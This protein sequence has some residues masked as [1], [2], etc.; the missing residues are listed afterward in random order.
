MFRNT[1]SLHF[2]PS[3]NLRCR[4]RLVQF[5]VS[6]TISVRRVGDNV[7]ASSRN[8]IMTFMGD[9]RVLLHNASVFNRYL[10]LFNCAVS[11]VPCSIPRFSISLHLLQSFKKG[12]VFDFM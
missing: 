3:V 12:F 4:E 10:T 9:L 7:V 2:L 1:I 5:L 6:L 8:F 11:Q